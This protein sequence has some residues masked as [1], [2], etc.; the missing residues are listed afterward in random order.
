MASPKNKK[1]ICL[2]AISLVCGTAIFAFFL[3]YGME[4][5]KL[6]KPAARAASRSAAG[7]AATTIK[8]H[9]ST[10]TMAWSPDGKR[11]AF[12]A[13]FEYFGFR[14]ERAQ[15]GG[16]LGVFVLEVARGKIRRLT[17]NQGYHPLWLSSTRVAWGHS[18][19]EH[20][21]PGLYV[22]RLQRR[23]KPR[24]KRIGKFKGVYHTLPGKKGRVVFYS[25]WPEY[26][27]W[28]WVK[29]PSSKTHKLKVKVAKKKPPRRPPSKKGYYRRPRRALS[30]KIPKAVKDQC[31]QK[32]GGASVAVDA[33]G[34][35]QL[36]T[37]S[38]TVQIPQKA[39]IFH[40]YGRSRCS[41]SGHCGP[42]RPC[43][44][45]K[46]KHLA[47]FS[48]KQNRSTYNLHVIEVPK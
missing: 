29:P 14:N 45:P 27:R 41:V 42:V 30:W 33:S 26:K 15:H 17:T 37:P 31:L 39:Y 7:N 20:G 4:N 16:K 6:R 24:I 44:S 12:N 47:Y 43:L 35:I 2:R 36:T 11:L 3:I 48:Y 25:G 32:A 38:Q 13:A 40:N 8:L 34:N 9:G 22:A 21:K 46:G 28:V 1:R 23:G 18:P 19:Y 5:G 10:P